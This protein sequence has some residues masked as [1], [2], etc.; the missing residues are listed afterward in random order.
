MQERGWEVE[1]VENA[2][3]AENPHGLVIHRLSFPEEADKLGEKS[4]DLIT[5]WAVFEHLRDPR[6][7]FEASA[8]MLRP[9]GK[10]IVQVPNL[11]S[12]WARFARRED[13]PR[14]LYFFTPT[15]LGRLG[16]IAGLELRQ[17]HHTTDLFGGSG[18]GALR[19]LYV[20]A[21][22]GS[23]DFYFK[24]LRT[25]RRE[26]WRKWP[27]LTAGW[28]AIAA[29]ERIVLS[30]RLMRALHISG[31]IVVEF[32]RPPSSNDPSSA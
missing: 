20:R 23:V 19:L 22:G 7:A 1:G 13:I 27:A 21:L 9:G 25:S 12:I 10:L 16:A 28:T 32:E 8:R 26:R 14:H 24:V 31:Q 6:R 30:D 4:Y 15:T 29:L 2:G 3:V 18:R 5:A 11:R 17:V